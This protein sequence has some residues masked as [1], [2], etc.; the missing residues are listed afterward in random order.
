MSE[1]ETNSYGLLRRPKR[2]KTKL[3]R[4]K[5]H[6]LLGVLFVD[7]GYYGYFCTSIKRNDYGKKHR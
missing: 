6:D 3:S 4:A 5:K 1:R 7:A 2:K